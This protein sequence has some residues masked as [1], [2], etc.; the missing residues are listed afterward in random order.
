ML[1]LGKR[2]SLTR[3]GVS[4]C[5]FAFKM[6]F[7]S[8]HDETIFLRVSPKWRK[9]AHGFDAHRRYRGPFVAHYAL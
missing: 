3:S 8:F 1:R 9:E 5:R 6:R 2:R 7:S 4:M